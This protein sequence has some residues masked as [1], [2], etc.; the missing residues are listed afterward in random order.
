M[1]NKGFFWFL[2][3]LLTAVCVYQLSFTWVS[4]SIETKADKEAN[5]R[6]ADLKKEA[7]GNNNI[8]FLPN[9]TQV[10]FSKPEAEELAK[11]AFINQILKEKAETKVYPLI[12]STFSEVKKRSLAFGLD[13]V[14]GMSVTLEI[15]IPDLV[16]NFARNPRDLQFKKPY[17]SA[18]DIY[19]SQ[20]GDFISIFSDENKRINNGMKL[21]R[22]FATTDME[23]LGINS[24]DED[25]EDF[26]RNIASSSMNGVEQ[27]MNKRINQFGVAQPN[28]QKDPS[29]NR[30]YIEL[31]GVQD[32][33]TVAERLQ[34]TA[35][36]QFFETYF[37]QE[38]GSQWQQATMVSRS[39]ET[40]VEDVAVVADTTKSADTTKVAEVKKAEP[41][42]ALN[43][44]QKG[45]ADYVKG[46]GNYA[47]GY[48]SPED[49]SAVDAIL[50]RRD[51]MAV[52]PEDLKFMWSA[53]LEKVETNSKERAHMLY[54]IRVPETGKAKVGGKDI[55]TASTGY[56]QNSGKI[57]V[58]LSMTEE[59]A[60]K[61]A[62]MT[63]DNVE[64]IV[65]ITM[66]NVVYSAPRVMNAITGG[67]TQ[68]S[69]TF[70][71]DEAKDLSGL[72]NGG[73]LPAP[74]IIKE[75]TK[76]GPTI[77]A[78]NTRTGLISFAIALAFVFA[79]MFF[80]YG[81]AGLVADIALLAN[82]VFIFG[83]LASFGAVLTLAGIAGIVLTIG[84]AVD[85]NVLVFE[86]IREEIANG[87]EK[88][89]AID[90]GYKKALS[91]IIDANVTTLLTAIVL[92]IFGSG[93]IESFA[94]T[95]IIGIFT[96]VFAALV[97]SRLIFIWMMNKGKD[98][99]FETKTTKGAFKS[100]K[101][102]F[103]GKRKMYYGISSILVIGSV[104]LLT[105]KGLNPSIEFSGGRTF[106]VKF[107]KV[108]GNDIEYL[109]NELLTV[110]K[111]E[112]KTASVD[113]K[114]KS[115]NY[116]VEIT[117]NYKL[118]NE[119]ANEEVKE[120][121][122]EGLAK[123]SAK[124]GGFDIQESRSVSASVS[125]ELMSSSMI[126]IIL[127]LII[128]FAYIFMRF[129]KW[130]YSAGAILAIA[131]DVLIVLGLFALFHGIL[132][133]NMDVDQAFIAAILTVIGYSINDTVIV[134][135][136]IRE[137]LSWKKDVNQLDEINGALNSTLS[138]TVNT[139]FTTF[140]VL[141]T[142]FILGGA[143][144]KGFVFALMIGVIV[145]TY[146]SLCIA[147]PVLIDFTKKIKA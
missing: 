75:Q 139:S 37:P 143:A 78:E 116:F 36:L 135:D 94:T 68:I 107:D 2:T 41:L 13:L 15:S 115:N 46:A 105:T 47:M 98:I 58:D 114:T 25:V 112:G 128:M 43:N 110:F 134:F 81:K 121:L 132:P 72:L 1:R 67:N 126:A 56:D 34:S 76:V 57:T 84:M 61:W 19:T 74:C 89:A 35:N 27:I 51:V 21:N 24:S 91:S 113:I 60:D 6:V 86:R 3:I 85:A 65:A 66:D 7:A 104:I 70:S 69:G 50:S 26:L 23:G 100:T 92:K 80:Y 44:G 18:Y 55:K 109:R 40:K 8:G 63:S 111:E 42:T 90:E 103:V 108:V 130:Q 137:E 71:I 146:S 102:N 106:G 28:I 122:K 77:G 145:G 32:E 147:T 96:S 97:V 10:D 141:L 138:R 99:S 133:F 131:H 9:N 62:L 4:S 14:G 22:L 17:E 88:H 16:A 59:G 48:V 49:K 38:I 93:P 117:T 136:R 119:G 79:Y 20:G 5:E 29:N 53:D 73:A 140:I 144:I 118:N 39:K 31:P 30:L 95:L 127:S 54:A 45:L 129:G 83:S 33:A 123:T 120:K 52:F 12:G 124:F 11:A 101:I 82:M 142:V 125:K 64:R 87:K